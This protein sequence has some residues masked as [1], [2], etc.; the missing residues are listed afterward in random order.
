MSS[1][2]CSSHSQRRPLLSRRP[3]ARAAIGATPQETGFPET[4]RVSEL[5]GLVR[6]HFPAATPSAE[7]LDRFALAHLARRQA[8]G[9]SGGERRRLA[10]ALAFAGAPQAVF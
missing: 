4:L 1:T 7:L 6:A 10:V 3:A 9:L 8:G 2:T 5:V